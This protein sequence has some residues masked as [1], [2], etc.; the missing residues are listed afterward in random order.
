MQCSVL[1]HLITIQH[2]TNDLTP[3]LCMQ[4]RGLLGNETTM[5]GSGVPHTIEVY[6]IYTV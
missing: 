3:T 4:A 2:N 1:D 5:A 6:I